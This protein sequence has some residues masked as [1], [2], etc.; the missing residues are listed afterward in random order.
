MEDKEY[1]PETS[2]VKNFFFPQLP[3]KH[4]DLYV[5]KWVLNTDHRLEVASW[6]L[7]SKIGNVNYC[8]KVEFNFWNDW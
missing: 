8:F 3:Q 6:I 2:L 1:G 4:G 5:F 7:E